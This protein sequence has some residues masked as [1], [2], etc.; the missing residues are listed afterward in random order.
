M[1]R[2]L[3]A[4]S[5]HRVRSIRYHAVILF[6]GLFII[7]LSTQSA[8]ADASLFKHKQFDGVGLKGDYYYNSQGADVSLGIAA[9]S[10]GLGLM[11]FGGV[12]SVNYRFNSQLISGH[13]GLDQYL[14]GFGLQAG[15]AWQ[16]DRQEKRA[17]FGVNYG[18]KLMLGVTPHPM[19]LTIGGQ[20]YIE[21]PTEFFISYS[22]FTSLDG[23]SSK[24]RAPSKKR[25]RRRGKSVYRRTPSR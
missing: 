18:L 19:F 22:I 20:T 23:R 25:S 8:S 11:S 13:V 16:V 10:G 4:P 15:L 5:D 3:S 7:T 14:L 21:A 24:R 17:D 6:L 2:R 12:G 1:I 9:R